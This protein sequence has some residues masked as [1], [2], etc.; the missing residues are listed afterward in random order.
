LPK[1]GHT[2]RTEN[3]IHLQKTG[4]ALAVAWREATPQVTHRDNDYCGQCDLKICSK[5]REVGPDRACKMRARV[6]LGSGSGF[7]LR[8][9]AFCGPGCLFSIIGLGLGLLQ[10]K[11]KIQARRLCPKPRPSQ[12][13]AFGLFSKSPS[14]QCGL[15][16]GPAPALER[17]R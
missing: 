17:S 2:A 12:A 16:P 10:N 5:M 6:G 14:P 7:T 9:W 13:Q 11:P 8:A 1:S 15:G 4:A 3:S